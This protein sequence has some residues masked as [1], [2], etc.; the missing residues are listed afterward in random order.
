M[1][2]IVRWHKTHISLFIKQHSKLK[3]KEKNSKHAA[4]TL[5]NKV[6]RTITAI[7]YKNFIASHVGH[8]EFLL[9]LARKSLGRLKS[10]KD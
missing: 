7:V 3:K 1:R 6:Y 5:H 4:T 9:R 10:K 2:R 8:I